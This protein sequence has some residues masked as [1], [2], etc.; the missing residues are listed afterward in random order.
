MTEIEAQFVLITEG[1][2]LFDLT[3]TTEDTSQGS[4]AALRTCVMV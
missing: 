2:P 3:I 1:P 4:R